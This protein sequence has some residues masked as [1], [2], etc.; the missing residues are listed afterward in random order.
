MAQSTGIIFLDLTM[1]KEKGIGM[2]TAPLM[3]RGRWVDRGINSIIN[4]RE[5]LGGPDL[6]ASDVNQY[7]PLIFCDSCHRP[8]RHTPSGSAELP[9]LFFDTETPAAGAELWLVSTRPCSCLSLR[10]AA[11]MRSST[12]DSEVVWSDSSLTAS[13]ARLSAS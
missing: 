13:S 3:Q 2:K 9:E 12:F 8:Q 10:T 7:L 1:K 11:W 5:K 4:N 6:F